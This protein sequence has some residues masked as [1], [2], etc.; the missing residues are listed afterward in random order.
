[1]IKN[2]IGS[3]LHNLPS[4][5]FYPC[6]SIRFFS[7]ELRLRLQ[8]SLQFAYIYS[9]TLFN[10]FHLRSIMKKITLLLILFFYSFL[11]F[12]QTPCSDF[13]TLDCNQVAVTLP[14]NLN[15]DGNQGGIVS[16]GF[17][18]VDPPSSRLSAD[19][20]GADPNI[21][22]LLS[23]NLSLSGGSLNVTA[24]NGINYSQTSG[25]PSSTLTNS[26]MNAL[27]LGFEASSNNIDISAVVDQPNFT[28]SLNSGNHG[29]QQAGIWF[30]L[31]ENNFVKLVVVKTSDTQQ[32]IQFAL[33]H[34][35]PS[36]AANLIIT[37]LNTG[38]FNTS[39]VS[40]ISFRISIDPSDNSVRGFYSLD[41]GIELQVEQSGT[42]LLTAPTSFLDGTD[43]DKNI[44]TNNLIF[45]GI[46]TTT[47]RATGGSMVISYNSFS[48]TEAVTPFQAQINFQNNPSFTTPPAGYLADYGKAFGNS[49]VIIGSDSYEYGWKLASDGTTA[50]DISNEASNNGGS[51]ALGGCR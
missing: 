41:G 2:Y 13:S 47:R 27:G 46:M 30:G 4:L 25:S 31:N 26:Q 40:Q 39:G 35:D 11:A 36:N 6:F 12:S 24:T 17:T 45:A 22:G 5:D 37:E 28:S 50:I 1:M 38:N 10:Q 33:E 49:S 43:H 18:M 44:G 23:G 8:D 9:N 34:T 21:T 3:K 32:K 19:D 15:F 14:I 48:V 51:S 16:T 29:S 7:S 20:T 42:D